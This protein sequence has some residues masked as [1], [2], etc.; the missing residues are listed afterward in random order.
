MTDI[1]NREAY[2]VRQERMSPD[3]WKITLAAETPGPIAAGQ[4]VH[5]RCEEEANDPLL[6]RPFSVWD[7]ERHGDAL[8]NLDLVYTVVGR[9]TAIL[10]GKKPLDRVGFLGP[11]GR[12]Y[13]IQ[14]RAKTLLFVA[15]GVG[16]VPFYLFAKQ[17]RE[18]GLQ[19]RMI[20]LFGARN[21][22]MLYGIDEFSALGVETHAATDDG[23][24]GHRGLVTKLMEKVL[25]RI[26][27]RGLQVY[28]CG[29]E[30]MLEAVL[31]IVRR[32]RLRCELS[33][34]K[35]MGCA[36]GACRACVTAVRDGRGW[37][38]S[39]SCIEGPCYDAADLVPGKV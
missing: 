8:T 33:M 6:R 27:R 26:P 20:L 7:V 36:M 10:A 39:R 9:G 22:S 37:R 28:S 24:R 23:S 3:C 15:G 16:I 11:L 13:T 12:G 31:K 32:R 18:R 14:P 4:F 35:R 17:V 34:E 2:V 1:I 21:E 38:Y 29:P 25:V 19:P 30:P 5:V